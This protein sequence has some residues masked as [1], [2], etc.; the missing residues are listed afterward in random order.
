[1]RRR[2]IFLLLLSLGLFLVGVDN[3]VLYTALPTLRAELDA[4]E[5]EALWII[6]AYPLVLAGFLLGTGTL[7]DKIGHRRMFTAG[8]VIF[9]VASLAAAFA[10]SA[11]AL[12]AAR[13]LLGLGAAT[14]MPATLALVRQTFRDPKELSTAIG[15]WA[16]VALLG[17][18][19]G[20]V[21][22]GALLE[23][24]WWGSVFLINVPVV[25]VSLIA[26]PALAPPNEPHPDKH[27]D[28]ASSLYALV[29]MFG[30][31][32]FIKELS[33]GRSPVVLALSAAAL[34][35]GAT[36][37][38]LR[39][40]RLTEPLLTFDVF[41]DR[42]FTGGVLTAGLGMFV[43][44]GAELLTTQRF[45]LSAGFSPLEAGLLTA[46][47]ALA[48]FPTSIAG[49]ALLHRLG[50]RTLITGGFTVVALGGA[51]VYAGVAGDT[52]WPVIAGMVGVGAGT[53]AAFGVASTAIVGSAPR[54]RAGMAAAVEE[55]SYEFG[56]LLSVTVAGSLI[57]MFYAR[58]VPDSESFDAS[59][60]D[61]SY[62]AVMAVLT[63]VA[64]LAAAL[65]AILFRGN[66]K[67]TSYAHEQEDADPAGDRGD[68]RK[69]R[70][71][72]GDL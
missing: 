6:N 65:T 52:L 9:G 21:I 50:F 1:M 55:V 48:S 69:V 13:A 66:P 30:L 61:A 23:H 15:V 71:V 56:T 54:H 57:T 16:S 42:L 14:M 7:G 53:G 24:F 40:R 49:G 32:M 44:A 70:A 63:A 58:Q 67:E 41:R 51:A 45:Q 35:I 12:V 43:L 8:L 22:G 64:V 59:A 72:G 2:W 31:V 34:A 60:Y 17:A 26:L 46:A 38:V 4:S 28:F 37:F 19:A 36:V 3:S 10:P 62:L 5:L 27:W 68:R 25:L 33:A 11:W 18:A 29:A 39:Q 20:P 47:G